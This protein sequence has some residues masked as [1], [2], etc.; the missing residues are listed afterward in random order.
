MWRHPPRPWLRLSIA[1]AVLAAAG[2]VI[3]LTAVERVY[4][5]A[6][7]SLTDQAI[8]QDFADLIVIA[9]AT[10]LLAVLGQRGSLRA[11]SPVMYRGPLPS[12]ARRPTPSTCWTWP[13]SCRRRS[14][15]GCC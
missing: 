12:W 4:G 14:R 13:S 1:A 6:Y 8:A 9:P 11:W 7:P 15:S 5:D 2:N 3:G 10:V